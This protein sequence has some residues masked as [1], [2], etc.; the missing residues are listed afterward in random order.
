[1]KGNSYILGE[2]LLPWAY[3]LRT[4]VMFGVTGSVVMAER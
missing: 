2:N 4:L 1:M 3:T